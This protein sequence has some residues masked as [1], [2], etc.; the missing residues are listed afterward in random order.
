MILEANLQLALCYSVGFGTEKDIQMATSY[1]FVAAQG[2]LAKA[3]EVSL[4]LPHALFGHRT[5]TD[6]VRMWLRKAA[7]QGSIIAAED[8]QFVDASDFESTRSEAISI[9]RQ[10]LEESLGTWLDQYTKTGSR[11][12][13]KNSGTLTGKDILRELIA[14]AD[15][16]PSDSRGAMSDFLHS[17]RKIISRPNVSGEPP[18]LAAIR[19]GDFELA[20]FLVKTKVDIAYRGSSGETLLHWLS[21]SPL[22]EAT[23]IARL[24]LAA[25]VDMHQPTYRIW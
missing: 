17:C 14:E 24:I 10:P 23:D 11:L 13:S 8:L 20:S 4:R 6:E 25:G 1:L 12:T 22:R 16:N 19:S 2:G 21:T 9:G 15:S 7:L 5:F 3:M 18:L